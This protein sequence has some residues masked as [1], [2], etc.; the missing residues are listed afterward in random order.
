MTLQSDEVD[1]ESR[2][3]ERAVDGDIND[4]FVGGSCIETPGTSQTEWWSVDLL[5]DYKIRNIIIKARKD[6]CCG[7][8]YLS[9]YLMVK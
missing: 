4:E 2:G 6:K 5:A 3:S 7:M 8:Y 9:H 1:G